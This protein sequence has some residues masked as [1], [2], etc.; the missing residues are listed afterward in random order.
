MPFIIKTFISQ[1]K[2]LAY[3]FDDLFPL[4]QGSKMKYVIQRIL[5]NSKEHN[6]KN[7][8]NHSSFVLQFS[9]IFSV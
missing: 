5:N 9:R 4:N 6:Q 7:N 1:I 8:F 2:W 3:I